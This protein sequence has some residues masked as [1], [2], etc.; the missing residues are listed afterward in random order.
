MTRSV[1]AQFGLVHQ[2]QPFLR[3]ADLLTV[4]HALATSHL[5]YWN[6]TLIGAAPVN[7]PGTPVGPEQVAA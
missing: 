6:Y 7:R 5:D 3:K 4:F 2:L 1:F